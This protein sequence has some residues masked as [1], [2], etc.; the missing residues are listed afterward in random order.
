MAMGLSE[1]FIR[2]Y[3]TLIHDESIR[4]QARIMNRSEEE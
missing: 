4:Q 2:G 1:Q 3:L